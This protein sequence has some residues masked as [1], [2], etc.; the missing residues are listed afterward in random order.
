[1]G[2]GVRIDGI[3]I[4][5]FHGNCRFVEW[6]DYSRNSRRWL[7]TDTD[8]SCSFGFR[9]RGLPDLFSWLG[10]QNSLLNLRTMATSCEKLFGIHILELHYVY[11]DFPIKTV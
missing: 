7:P 6:P 11:H 8:G 4:W 1:M 3:R 9:H 10:I 2:F 5:Y